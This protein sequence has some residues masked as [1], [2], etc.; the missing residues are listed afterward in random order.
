MATKKTP[1]KASFKAIP[2]GTSVSWPYRSGTGH[3]SIAGVHKKGTNAG[4]TEYSIRQ[5]DNHVGEPKIV[6]HYGRV[7]SRKSKK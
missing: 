1:T 5:T 4:N 3:G 7:I 2:T 6:F